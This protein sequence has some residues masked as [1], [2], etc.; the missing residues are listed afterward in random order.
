MSVQKRGFEVNVA[1]A[2]VLSN[3]DGDGADLGHKLEARAESY[4][5]YRPCR[6]P[7]VGFFNRRRRSIQSLKAMEDRC[8]A[9]ICVDAL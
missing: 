2:G 3:R 7:F 8:L 4:R 1:I 5:R 6:G 9:S